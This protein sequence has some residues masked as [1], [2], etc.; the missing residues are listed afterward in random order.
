M[1]GKIDA[2]IKQKS[3]GTLQPFELKTGRVNMNNVGHRGQLLI[4][5]LLLGDIFGFFPDSGS[6]FYLANG[7][8]INVQARVIEVQAIM[9]QRNM[10]ARYIRSMDL[11]SL[12]PMI[13]NDHVCGR[14]FQRDTCLSVDFLG[15]RDSIMDLPNSLRKR[16]QELFPK[17]PSIRVVAFVKDLLEA[18]SREEACVLK[19]KTALWTVPVEE[20]ISGGRCLRVTV[21][22]VDTRR[23]TFKSL[24]PIS[25]SWLSVGDA[26]VLSSCN[27]HYGMSIGYILDILSDHELV[28]SMDRQLLR[29]NKL[30][31][32]DK[33]ELMGSF[34][35]W[36]SAS[37]RLLS[38]QYMAGIVCEGQA[39]DFD[40][41]DLQIDRQNYDDHQV[42]AIRHVLSTRQFS[43]VQ[44]MPGTGKTTTLVG[45]LRHI[46]KF[47]GETILL[48]SH[49]HNAIDNILVKLSLAIQDSD[50]TIPDS[51]NVQASDNQKIIRLGPVE[52]LSKTVRQF[53]PLS[54]PKLI[55]SL[56]SARIV[57]C[58]CHSIQH[59]LSFFLRR[60]SFD[61][62]FVDEASQLTIPAAL[63]GVR[64]ARKWVLIGDPLQ[65]PPL[66]RSR[67]TDSPV[68]N[69]LSTSLQHLLQTNPNAS[70]SLCKQYR[71]NE[72]IMSVANHL[73]YE[74]RL[75]CGNASVAHRKLGCRVL[76][77]T[78]CSMDNT[79]KSAWQGMVCDDSKGVVFIDYKS[80]QE[81]R[82][83]RSFCN[84]KEAELVVDIVRLLRSQGINEQ[85]IAVISP[86]RPQLRLLRAKMDENDITS[87]ELDTVDRFQGRD[88]PCVIVSLV[89]ANPLGLVGELVADW[90]RINVAFTRAMAKLIVIGHA[91]TL[92]RCPVH[93]KF[94][95]Y[96]NGQGW[97]ISI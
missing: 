50:G 54:N 61:W 83:G 26:V 3:T 68:P 79:D 69:V 5:T 34:G 62:C 86:F 78:K 36:R 47:S 66:V 94:I 24:D 17:Q 90:Q 48:V 29:G 53:S 57:A 55:E 10:I 46:L 96:C 13:L 85:S 6:L 74:G 16:Q 9:K 33:D 71:M 51:N 63:S 12:P 84:L 23:T 19:A 20:R 15:K 88:F 92:K 81:D 44:G 31:T 22:D 89:R 27:G 38:D 70:V 2:T 4:Y 28:A 93:C 60:K 18:I 21:K 65:L 67:D 45:I 41:H 64:W 91:D 14:C 76:E 7:N 39:P 59:Y 82:V 40:D 11:N 8:T 72:Q 32:L 97:T 58:T 1:K 49:T 25:Q 42:K 80:S 56:E 30:Y 35:Q 52:K 37:L 77:E 75:E 43:M 95:E 73:V 87:I